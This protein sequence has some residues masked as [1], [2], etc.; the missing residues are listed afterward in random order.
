M[1]PFTFFAFITSFFYYFLFHLSGAMR[2]V[3]LTL[4]KKKRAFKKRENEVRKGKYTAR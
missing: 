4:K 2:T 3:K 1:L